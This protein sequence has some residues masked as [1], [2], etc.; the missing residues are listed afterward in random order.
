[1]FYNPSYSGALQAYVS[2]R[3]SHRSITEV[4]QNLDIEERNVIF[5]WH[6]TRS[7]NSS[8]QEDILIKE[9]AIA[10]LVHARMT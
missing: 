4:N 6:G 10:L 5:A 8:V 9:R 2:H 3:S 7:E 1:M